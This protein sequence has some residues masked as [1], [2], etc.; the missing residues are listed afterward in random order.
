MTE[1]T[2]IPSFFEDPRIDLLRIDL[3]T[4]KLKSTNNQ[5][6]TLGEDGDN[7]SMKINLRLT[8]KSKDICTVKSTQPPR[9]VTPLTVCL[10]VRSIS[11]FYY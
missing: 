8:Q 11:L 1:W 6:C 5:Y 7:L 9:R 3:F 10:I 2:K 4:V